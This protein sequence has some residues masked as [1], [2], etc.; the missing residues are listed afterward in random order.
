MSMA[1]TS[2]QKSSTLSIPQRLYPRPEPVMLPPTQIL[3]MGWLSVLAVEAGLFEGLY[4]GRDHAWEITSQ[5]T[6]R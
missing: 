1:S 5:W 2:D 6:R 4:F 3:G